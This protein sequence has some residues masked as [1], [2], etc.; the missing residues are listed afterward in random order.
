MNLKPIGDRLVV[1][2][3]E[4]G[5]KTKGGII[6]PDAAKEKPQMGK[7]IAVGDGRT[8]KNG[9]KQESTWLFCSAGTFA[10]ALKQRMRPV[11][12][13]RRPHSVATFPSM[14]R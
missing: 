11:T 10:T 5:E 1:Q 12:V 14:A 3:Q 4:A 6:L 13:P 9:K 8:L 2:R 7:V